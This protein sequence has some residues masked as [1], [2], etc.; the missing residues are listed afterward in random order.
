MDVQGDIA[1][2]KQ[3]DVGNDDIVSPFP[4]VLDPCMS[5]CCKCYFSEAHPVKT[6]VYAKE[7]VPNPIIEHSI[8]DR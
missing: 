8:R 6:T 5:V 1:Y 4:R 2:F 7:A 3:T